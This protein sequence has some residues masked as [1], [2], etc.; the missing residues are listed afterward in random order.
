M[1]DGKIRHV[2]IV[3]L[4]V[5]VVHRKRF[6]SQIIRNIIKLI[7]SV[8]WKISWKCSNTLQIMK[9]TQ[10]VQRLASN[11]IILKVWHRW[12]KIYRIF[13]F[14]FQQR[15]IYSS[16]RLLP[17]HCR[18]KKGNFLCRKFGRWNDF[19]GYA[20][21]SIQWIFYAKLYFF[22]KIYRWTRYQCE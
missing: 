1:Y 4:Y 3:A 15:W 17:E 12:K 5:D 21:I 6:S 7:V 20:F 9:N 19:Y 22:L 8:T 10:P 16:I 13:S 14:L 18:C 11:I 2:E